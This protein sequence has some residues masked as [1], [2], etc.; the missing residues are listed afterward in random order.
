[1]PK[2]MAMSG[3]Q[4]SGGQITTMDPSL[5]ALILVV[6]LPIGWLASEFHDNRGIRIILG[7]LAIAMSFFV[8]FVVGSLEQLRSN[9]YFG[10]TSKSLIET[11]VTELEAGNSE[12]VLDRLKKLQD[13]YHP[14][15]ETRA[16]YKELVD[17]YVAQFASEDAER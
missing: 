14:T 11:T 3:C 10:D 2:S 13:K 1:M 6:L 8:A 9:T 4:T 12:Q 17:E 15:Y 7:V 5:I 16:G